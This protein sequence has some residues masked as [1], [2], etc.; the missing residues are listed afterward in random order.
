M[1]ELL[2]ELEQTSETLLYHFLTFL[3][4]YH[5]RE[6]QTQCTQTEL[7]VQAFSLTL[8]F[9]LMMNNKYLA[10]ERGHS[11]ILYYTP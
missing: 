7:L 9:L 8:Q 1:S 6:G 5:Q 4:Q 11:R 3:V 10:L 2:P